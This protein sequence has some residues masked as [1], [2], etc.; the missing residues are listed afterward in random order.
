LFVL[1]DW[2]N[3]GADYERTLSAWRDNIEQAWPT[4][5]PRYDER[6]RRMWRYYLAASIGSFRS[7][8]LQLWQLVLSPEG[9]AGGYVAPR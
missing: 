2:H 1:E 9:V 4:L 7:R 3:F 8:Q 6:F 5:G